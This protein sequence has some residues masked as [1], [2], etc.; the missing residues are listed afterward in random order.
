M[1]NIGTITETEVRLAKRF[2]AIIFTMDIFPTPEILL[3]A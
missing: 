1:S 2:E 3:E